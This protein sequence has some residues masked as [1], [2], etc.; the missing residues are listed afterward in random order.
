MPNVEPI[1]SH[2]FPLM[3]VVARLTGLFVFTPVLSSTT[4]PTMFKAL[5]AFG[6]GVALV[7]FIPQ[8]PPSAS[9][10]MVQLVPLLFAELLVGITI[11]LIAAVPLY[12]MQM[13]GYMMGYQVGLSLA[14]SFNPE[15]DTSGSVVGQMLYFMGA[16]LFI[17]VGGLDVLYLTLAE[18]LRTAPIGAFTAMDVP[19][20]FFVAVLSSGFE[21]AIRVSVPIL[22]AVSMTQVA[23]GLVMKTMPQINIMSIGFAIQIM[24][25]L[26]ILVLMLNVIAEVAMDEVDWVMQGLSDWVRNLAPPAPA[27]APIG[28]PHG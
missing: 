25:G 14:E 3:L 5:L 28:G 15:L 10:D 20:D 2:L 13:G 4:I 19:L 6:F 23:M 24:V 18:S 27:S 26:L 8:I 12:A 1:L 11:G 21:M 16:M 9:I 22:A 7:P 17:S